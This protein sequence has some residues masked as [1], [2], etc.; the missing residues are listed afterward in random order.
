[1]YVDSVTRCVPTTERAVLPRRNKHE[2]I[3][4]VLVHGMCSMLA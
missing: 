2:S 4:Y 3:S 1:M